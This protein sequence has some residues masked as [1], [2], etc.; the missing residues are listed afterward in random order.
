MTLGIGLDN[1]VNVESDAEFRLVPTALTAAITADRDAGRR[2]LAVVGVAGTTS[3]TAVDPLD[4]IADICAREQLWFHVDAAYAGVAAAVPELRPLFAGM[5]RADSVVLNPHKWLFTPM[6]CS[7]FLVRR[8][9]ALKRAFSLVPAYLETAEQ[10]AVINVMDYGF[11]L[12]HRFRALK[13]WMVLRAFGARGI[14][15]RIRHHCALASGFADWVRAEPGWSIEAPHP[16]SV[17]CFRHLAGGDERSAQAHNTRILDRVNA[18][19]EVFLSHTM[20]KGRYVLRVAVGNLRT[21]RAHLER[22]W[23]LLRDAARG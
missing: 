9:E 13:L 15:D 18:S 22:A 8:P 4:R 6:D 17:V 3:S 16:F 23:T 12:G 2:P 21:S 11:Q 20:L 1:V 7:V 10:D 5:E 19:G 14:V